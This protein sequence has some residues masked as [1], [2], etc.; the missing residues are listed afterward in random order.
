MAIRAWLCAA[1][2]LAG[3]VAVATQDAGWNGAGWYQTIDAPQG[4]CIQAGPYPSELACKKAMNS[5]VPGRSCR[6]LP[7]A[8]G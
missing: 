5:S 6:E 3:S 7:T 4:W 2:L 1:G 8:P